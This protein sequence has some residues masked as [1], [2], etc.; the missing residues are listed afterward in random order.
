ME[1]MLIKEGRIPIFLKFHPEMNPIE[2]V[3]AQ[4]KR[5]TKAHYKYSL[6]SLRKNIPLAYDSV[7]LENIQNHFRKIRQYMFTYVEGLTPGTELDERVKRQL[8]HI[9][10]LDKMSNRV[11]VY[12]T[13]YKSVFSH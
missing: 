8:N 9:G 10:E 7:S 2:R 4:L 5:Y 6:P 1:T 11:I 12:F 13:Y 3:W